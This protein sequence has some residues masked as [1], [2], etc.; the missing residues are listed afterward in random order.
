[1]GSEIS[2]VKPQIGAAAPQS[3]ARAALEKRLRKAC[4][5]FEA[6]FMRQLLEKMRDTVPKGGLLGNSQGEQ[7]FR[8]M[9]DGAMADEMAKSGAVGLGATLYQQLSRIVLKE[10]NP[11]VPP[12]KPGAGEAE[13]KTG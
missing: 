12:L 1:M 11:A 2:S 6:V 7:I 5:D 13:D 3:A 8:S 10:L 9:L 4:Q